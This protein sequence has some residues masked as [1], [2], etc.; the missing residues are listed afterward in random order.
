MTAKRLPDS[1]AV[2]LAFIEKRL[3]EGYSGEIRIECHQGGIRRTH[4]KEEE[5]LKPEDMAKRLESA[6]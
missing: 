3:R 4:W 6:A 2:T 5:C 1:V